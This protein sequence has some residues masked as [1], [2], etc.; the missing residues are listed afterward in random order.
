MDDKIGD[1][2]KSADNK[3]VKFS[4]LPTV[5]I[6]N[7]KLVI[8]AGTPRSYGEL[9]NSRWKGKIAMADP[10]K[11]GSAYTALLTM[12]QVISKETGETSDDVIAKIAKNVD[13]G[14]I[15][16]S[17]NVVNAVATGE[18]LVG[19]TSEEN[20]LKNM[21]DGTDIAMIYPSEG[22]SVIPDG[23]AIIKNAPHRSNAEKFMEFVVSDDVQRLLEDNLYRRS[24]RKDITT[25]KK[26][27]EI[28]Y[29]I[30]Y[31]EKNRQSILKCWQKEAGSGSEQVD[32]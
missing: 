28:S 21:T 5:I 22:T 11:S 2:Y 7:R 26:I 13:G 25:K 24:V 23:A 19:I 6:Y 17:Q 27:K 16:G 29:D 20:A 9:V 10:E 14:I 18:K 31:S 30:D 3:Y 1:S 15:D 8:S 32:E 4:D 12:V